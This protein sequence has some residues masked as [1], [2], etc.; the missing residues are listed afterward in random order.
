[1]H[2]ESKDVVPQHRSAE[3]KRLQ[4]IDEK[5][6][7]MEDIITTRKFDGQRYQVWKAQVEAVLMAKDIE[8]V[9]TGTIPADQEARQE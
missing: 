6:S 8:I 5:A 9:L 4:Q 2:Q 7:D 3:L 1:M